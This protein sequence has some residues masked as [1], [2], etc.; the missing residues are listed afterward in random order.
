MLATALVRLFRRETGDGNAVELERKIRRRAPAFLDKAQSHVKATPPAVRLDETGFCLGGKTQWPQ[1]AATTQTTWRRT[2]AKRKDVKP[3]AGIG[4]TI[5]HDHWRPYCAAECPPSNA[6]GLRNA[7]HLREL[8]AVAEINRARVSAPYRAAGCI[9]RCAGDIGHEGVVPT[10]L[11]QRLAACYERV[12][13]SAI[14][15]HEALPPFSQGRARRIGHHLALRLQHRA[16]DA[17]RFMTHAA[18]PFANNQAEQD[19]RILKVK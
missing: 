17:L 7:H 10:P 11:A 4:G 18:V 1:V 3:L 15:W 19:L 2:A 5:I 16:S 6:H 13:R 9:W 8:K 14:A 12:L